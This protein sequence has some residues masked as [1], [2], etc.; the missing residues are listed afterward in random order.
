[1]TIAT[2]RT[3]R[4]I[5]ITA[6]VAPV[7]LLAACNQT[8]AGQRDTIVQSCVSTA[9]NSGVAPA[10]ITAYCNCAADKMIEANMTPADAMDQ[11]KLRPIAMACVGE[12]AKGMPGAAP[13]PA[14]APAQ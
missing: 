3:Q 4:I 5:A 14:P 1:M 6:L 7:M 13:A 9:G 12:L 2:T 10:A 8:I 11:E